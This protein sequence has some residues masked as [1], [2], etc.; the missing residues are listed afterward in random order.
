MFTFFRSPSIPTLPLCLC[1][2]IVFEKLNCE[3]DLFYSFGQQ[4]ERNKTNNR[5]ISQTACEMS[6]RVTRCEQTPKCYKDLKI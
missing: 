1:L 5:K 4:I 3:N 2:V 6:N